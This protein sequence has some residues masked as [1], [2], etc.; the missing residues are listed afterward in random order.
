MDETYGF[1]MTKYSGYLTAQGHHYECM[2][3]IYHEGDMLFVDDTIYEGMKNVI[4]SADNE[5]K[6]Y[7]VPAIVA[8]NLDRYCWDFAASW[9]W[10]G[11][12]SGKYLK[13]FGSHYVAVFNESHFI[14][15]LNKWLFPDQPSAF[16]KALGSYEIPEEHKDYPRYNF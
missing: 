3:E 8:D 11:P 6:L 2:V 15:Y 1:N 7:S 13:L 5:V 14:D 16:V 10:H 9:V 4:L 12:E